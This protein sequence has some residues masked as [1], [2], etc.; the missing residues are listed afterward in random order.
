MKNLIKATVIFFAILSIVFA[1]ST[2]V[3]LMIYLAAFNT[4]IFLVISGILL[5]FFTIYMIKADLDEKS[6]LENISDEFDKMM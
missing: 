3:G 4:V 6:H 2:L 1:I 5:C